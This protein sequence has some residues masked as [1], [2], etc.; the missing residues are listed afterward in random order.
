MKFEGG[1][2]LSVY[3]QKSYKKFWPSGKILKPPRFHLQTLL[4]FQLGF[5]ILH[6]NLTFS[7]FCVNFRDL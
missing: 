7:F 6:E 2:T 4:I 1:G 3:Q 5:K